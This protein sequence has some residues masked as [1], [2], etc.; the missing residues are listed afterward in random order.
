MSNE[1]I[2]LDKAYDGAIK[3]KDLKVKIANLEKLKK[4]IESQY[5]NLRSEVITVGPEFLIKPRLYKLYCQVSLD[6]IQSLDADNQTL[7]LLNHAI[8]VLS[9]IGKLIQPYRENDKNSIVISLDKIPGF[10]NLT[11]ALV[12]ICYSASKA[13]VMR[14][15]YHNALLKFDQALSLIS[16]H[17]GDLFK[18]E[19]DNLM[20]NYP[21]LHAAFLNILLAKADCVSS[22]SVDEKMSEVC[23]RAEARQIYTDLIQWKSKSKTPFTENE[24]AQF[25]YNIT[26]SF[27]K[28][29]LILRKAND[30][31]GADLAFF[32]STRHAAM[33]IPLA[34]K[35]LTPDTQNAN[36]DCF[37][38]AK[39]FLCNLVICVKSKVSVNNEAD[40][41]L[42]RIFI[43]Y[44]ATPEQLTVLV[45]LEDVSVFLEKDEK[46][47]FE[48][49]N[50]NEAQFANLK[51]IIHSPAFKK[52]IDKSKAE[53]AKPEALPVAQI[54]S[55]V[56]AAISDSTKRLRLQVAVPAPALAPQPSEKKNQ[57]YFVSAMGCTIKKDLS[58][59][60]WGPLD[61][62]IYAAAATFN[63]H[64]NSVSTNTKKL[65]TADASQILV[66]K[67][68]IDP[69]AHL[70]PA[71]KLAYGKSIVER[72]RKIYGVDTGKYHLQDKSEK[73]KERYNQYWVAGKK[74]IG[75]FLPE[76]AVE[77]TVAI[78]GSTAARITAVVCN[79]RPKA[80]E[81]PERVI[82]PPPPPAR[83]QSSEIAE[84]ED[85]PDEVVVETPKKRGRKQET[86]TPQP[87]SSGKQTKQKLTTSDAK[88]AS[89]FIAV[90]KNAY[91][92]AVLLSDPKSQLAAI[93]T[94]YTMYMEAIIDMG[95]VNFRVVNCYVAAMILK[96]D[97]HMVLEQYDLVIEAYL[98]LSTNYGSHSKFKFE[99]QRLYGLYQLALRQGEAFVEEQPQ[100]NVVEVVVP[101]KKSSS[102]ERLITT[103]IEDKDPM[104]QLELRG[105]EQGSP[106]SA[107]FRFLGKKFPSYES[108]IPKADTLAQA[109]VVIVPAPALAPAPA[110]AV[111][112]PV[113]AHAPAAVMSVPAQVPKPMA[114]AAEPTQASIAIAS[115]PASTSAVKKRVRVDQLTQ[116][117]LLR[118]TPG[119]K[120]EEPDTE[121]HKKHK[122]N[123]QLTEDEKPRSSS[124][125]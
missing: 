64:F 97:A 119:K 89:Q 115:A 39:T 8:Q 68:V 121:Q 92:Q 96:I 104:G 32:Q 42:W 98:D 3:T 117:S 61:D 26:L 43:A 4:Q 62:A 101:P 123:E 113:P 109:A 18:Q 37:A 34:R 105:Q 55:P 58:I 86:I 63:T 120:V 40:E 1:K 5:T 50:I 112:I 76:N 85:L 84:D 27:H 19:C 24:L 69:P 41:L 118:R 46:S 106:R 103:M 36:D 44:V 81:Q 87:T 91:Q 78:G 114:H 82:A 48:M 72:L 60:D 57:P 102:Q 108:Y 90:F 125:K 22:F 59:K 25:Y 6:L 94:L 52:P 74:L 53:S 7:A 31:S 122:D 11:I 77:G 9:S 23:S 21:E 29:A 83:A 88:G 111:V 2:D 49:L 100:E 30:I 54:I 28:E 17:Y 38:L 75:H 107:P 67:L 15:S 33:A 80:E 73:G 95:K 45:N 66:Y 110:P 51:S 71:D 13:Y 116:L 12:N 79:C 20:A 47:R 65:Q 56:F 14:K 93:D 124:P 70:S 10:P 99:S 35:I 16:R